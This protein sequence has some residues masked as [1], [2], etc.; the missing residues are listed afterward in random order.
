MV[1]SRTFAHSFPRCSIARRFNNNLMFVF[2]SFLFFRF[3]CRA[4]ISMQ[5]FP[6][7]YGH[8]HE[9]RTCN[10]KIKLSHCYV[11]TLP[12]FFFCALLS[13]MIIFGMCDDNNVTNDL[14]FQS[15]S[16]FL[17]QKVILAAN[18]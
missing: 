11:H 14:I 9:R 10:S 8:A 6:Y 4:N 7:I 3:S 1:H 16:Y 13:S 5:P 12:F 17:T 15:P 18:F 2:L